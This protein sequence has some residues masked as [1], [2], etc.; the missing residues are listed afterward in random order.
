M[1]S[2]FILPALASIALAQ[3]TPEATPYEATESAAETVAET[4]TTPSVPVKTTIPENPPDALDF[5]G[6]REI[7]EPVTA[8]EV[9]IPGL[10]EFDVPY[11]L[12]TAIESVIAEQTESPLSVFPVATV[13]PDA[14]DIAAVAINAGGNDALVKREHAHAKRELAPRAACDPQATIPNVYNVDVSSY[15]KFKND[16]T[17]ASVASSATAPLGYFEAFKNLKGANSAYA[18]LGYSVVKTY[19]VNACAKKCT[20]KAGCLVRFSSFTLLWNCFLPFFI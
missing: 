9:E 16:A 13:L 3:I 5:K 2:F 10:E 17:I 14:S 1:R 15:S 12:P 19:D 7:P 11:D 8:E 4:V 18:Y 20:A 6:L